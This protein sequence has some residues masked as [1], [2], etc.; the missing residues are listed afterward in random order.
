MEA[1]GVTLRP[2]VCLVVALATACA[3]AQHAREPSPPTPEPV[4]AASASEPT[5]GEQPPVGAP[6]PHPTPTHDPAPAPPPWASPSSSAITTPPPASPSSATEAP[7][8][9]GDCLQYGSDTVVLRGVIER[10]TFPGPPNYESIATGDAKEIHWLLNLEWPF[11]VEAS[12][13]LS[14]NVSEAAHAKVR[15]VQL[16]LGGDD[17]PFEKYRKLVGRRVQATGE[18]FGAHTAHHRTDVLLQV[19]ELKALNRR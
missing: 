8:P 16:V 4:A 5:L 2:S 12:F 13:D 9:V 11:C 10:A 3:S 15:K 18:L 19:S 14:G 1:P 7:T 17:D 6:E